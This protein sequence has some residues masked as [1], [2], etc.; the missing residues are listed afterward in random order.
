MSEGGRCNGGI[1]LTV[2]EEEEVV[3]LNHLITCDPVV[4][5]TAF[6]RQAASTHFSY[7][8]KIVLVFRACLLRAASDSLGKEEDPEAELRRLHRDADLS[9]G[10]RHEQVPRDEYSRCAGTCILSGLCRAGTSQSL[11]VIDGRRVRLH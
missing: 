9:T 1:G 5:A 10:E 4:G 3:D 7:I 2:G 6:W 8:F 11:V